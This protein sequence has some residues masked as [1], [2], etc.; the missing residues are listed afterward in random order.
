MIHSTNADVVNRLRCAE[1]HLK[2]IIEMMISLSGS[3]PLA[4]SASFAYNAFGRRMSKTI[5]QQPTAFLYDRWNPV[6][7]LVPSGLGQ[8]VPTA[9]MLTGGVDE[10]FQRSDATGVSSFINDLLGSTLALSGLNG[11]FSS[12]YT[13]E[14][15]GTASINPSATNINSYQFA[16]RKNDGTGLYYY[17]ARYYS[18]TVQRFISQDPIGFAGGLNL[19]GYALESPTNWIDF[20][21]STSR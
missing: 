12:T 20:W 14:P 3:G 4:N 18:P 5:N 7:E 6:Q 17:R 11:T 21:G 2:T 15:F 8:F 16:G 9:N 1:G 10:F 13:Y 19:Y